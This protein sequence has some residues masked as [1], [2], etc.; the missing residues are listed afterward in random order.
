MKD[1]KN[2]FQKA[3]TDKE[4]KKS[5]SHQRTYGAKSRN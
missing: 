2:S 5:L 1:K 4:L 3:L